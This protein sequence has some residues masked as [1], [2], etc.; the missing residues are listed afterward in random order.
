MK[1]A[2]EN[3]ISPFPYGGSG[4]TVSTFYQQRNAQAE[5]LDLVVVNGPA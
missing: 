5:A 4:K 2:G 1:F 3:V